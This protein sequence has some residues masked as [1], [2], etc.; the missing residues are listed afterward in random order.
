MNVI[1]GL[2]SNFL[3]W[4]TL[5]LTCASLSAEW[6]M[7]PGVLTDRIDDCIALVKAQHK[8]EQLMRETESTLKRL[9]VKMEIAEAL[10]KGEMT[11]IDAAA[12]LCSLYEDPRAWRNP[13]YPR[14]ERHDG[15]GWCREAIDWTERYMTADHSPNQAKSVR[16]RLEAELQE[17]LNRH[18]TVTLPD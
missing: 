1:N 12:Y 7:E 6:L 10:K 18:G 4:T 13:N 11:L 8:G 5:V 9:H 14:P 17:Q 2:F 16:R 3:I 15:E